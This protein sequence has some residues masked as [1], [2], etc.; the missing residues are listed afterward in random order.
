MDI[1]KDA[2]QGPNLTNSIQFFG[3]FLNNV[4]SLFTRRA[5][6]KSTRV[7]VGGF[8]CQEKNPAHF[9]F[10]IPPQENK[11]DL[12]LMRY[13]KLHLWGVKIGRAGTEDPYKLLLRC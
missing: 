2:A 7:D 1:A 3:N 5:V 12:I 8:A 13:E 9:L 6:L 11:E 10:V 4:G